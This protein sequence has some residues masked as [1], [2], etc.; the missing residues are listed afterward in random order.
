MT[1]FPYFCIPILQY[2]APCRFCQQ[3]PCSGLISYDPHSGFSMEGHL[4]RLHINIRISFKFPHADPPV[5]TMRWKLS[6]TA[7]ACLHIPKCHKPECILQFMAYK[8][9]VLQWFACSQHRMQR[10]TQFLCRPPSACQTPLMFTIKISIKRQYVPYP[11]T[12]AQIS[13]DK[14]KILKCSRLLRT[15]YEQFPSV[16]PY[17]KSFQP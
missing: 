7:P 16:L 4:R 15:G 17:C 9:T 8:T 2:K 12:A 11:V 14:R 13:A 6:F 10:I 5:F 1:R 3:P